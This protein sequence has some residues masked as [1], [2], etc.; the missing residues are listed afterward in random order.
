MAIA[1]SNK[2][3][4]HAYGPFK[5]TVIM[6]IKNTINRIYKTADLKVIGIRRPM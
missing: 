2:Y 4:V 5:K 3:L 1:I 6:S